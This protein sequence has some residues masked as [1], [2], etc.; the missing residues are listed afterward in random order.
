MASLPH[1]HPAFPIT[2]VTYTKKVWVL[3]VPVVEEVV[4]IADD[5]RDQELSQNRQTYWRIVSVVHIPR[6]EECTAPR[7]VVA[8][9]HVVH[10]PKWD[11]W[12]TAVLE[13]KYPLER[14][15]VADDVCEKEPLRAV[16]LPVV[17]GAEPCRAS[18]MRAMLAPRDARPARELTSMSKGPL[19]RASTPLSLSHICSSK[20]SYCATEGYPMGFVPDGTVT[21]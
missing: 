7:D 10:I 19:R 21:R 1:E 13:V 15:Q 8:E 3:R 4:M 18:T 16:D 14:A 2:M 11:E 9:I 6:V 12:E 5:N 17:Q 20:A